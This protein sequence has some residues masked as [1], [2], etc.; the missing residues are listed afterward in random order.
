MESGRVNGRLPAQLR[1][2]R[3]ERGYTKHA[4][5]SVLVAFGDTRVL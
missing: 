1:P 5:G 2:V 4:E 3:L